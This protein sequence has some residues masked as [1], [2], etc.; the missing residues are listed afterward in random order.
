LNPSHAAP[1]VVACTLA[2]YASCRVPIEAIAEMRRN[3]GPAPGEALPATFLKHADEQT[4]AVIAA[5]FSAI[6]EHG[7]APPGVVGPFHEWGAVAGPRFLGRGNITAALPRFQAEGAWGV[8]PHVIP[9]RSLHSVPGTISQALKLQG[10]NFGVGGGPDCEAEALLA[11]MVMLHDMQLPGVWVALSRL[12]PESDC[13]ST[14]GLPAPGTQV[15][16]L[17]LALTPVASGGSRPILELS[18]SPA[19]APLRSPDIDSLLDLLE[20]L[21]WKPAVAHPLGGRGW[22]M[23]RRPALPLAGPHAPFLAQGSSSPTSSVR[24]D[25]L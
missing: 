15:Q 5:V 13:D 23:L 18:M 20:Q 2:G 21:D 10:P 4:V 25:C 1:S 9:H 24:S 22:L 16:A 3:P 7:L 17:A 14:T 19:T 6:Q 8:S 11:G 12:D